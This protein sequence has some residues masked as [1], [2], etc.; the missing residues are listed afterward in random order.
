MTHGMVL[1]KGEI[2]AAG[3]WPMIRRHEKVAE[4]FGV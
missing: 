4:L 1:E 3:P 2:V